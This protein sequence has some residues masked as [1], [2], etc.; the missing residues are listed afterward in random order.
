M[1]DIQKKIFETIVLYLDIKVVNDI[2]LDTNFSGVDS[3]TFIKI[4]VAL[5]SEFNFEFEDEM[6][7]ITKFPTVKSMIEYVESK[8]L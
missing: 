7:L 1:T 3:I 4:I 8:V 6:L 5:E 2:S